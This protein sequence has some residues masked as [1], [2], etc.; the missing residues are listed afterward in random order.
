M[1]GY[2]LGLLTSTCI[3]R[4]WR[5]IIVEYLP[6]KKRHSFRHFKKN[7]IKAFSNSRKVWNCS[8]QWQGSLHGDEKDVSW[9][10]DGQ[11]ISG[12]AVSRGPSEKYSY[13]SS[14]SKYISWCTYPLWLVNFQWLQMSINLV[15]LTIIY[16]LNCI[17]PLWLVNIPT[18]AQIVTDPMSLSMSCC[19]TSQSLPGSRKLGEALGPCWW[20]ATCVIYIYMGLSENSVPLNPMVNDHY[21]Y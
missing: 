3:W 13:I 4:I 11:I 1:L 2:Q 19:W 20:K 21:P 15:Q 14:I 5:S 10:H 8:S 17:S 18:K 9:Y 16:I 12:A 7:E 6:A